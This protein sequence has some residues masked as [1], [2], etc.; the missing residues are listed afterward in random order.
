[1]PLQPATISGGGTIALSNSIHNSIIAGPNGV[2]L[3][4]FD[5]TIHGGGYIGKG[6]AI[7]LINQA[8]GTIRADQ[9]TALEIYLGAGPGAQNHGLFEAT[10]QGNLRLYRTTVDN[11]GGTIRATGADAH[12]DVADSRITGGLL[13]TSGG[14]VI[15]AQGNASVL[16]G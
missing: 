15:R 1:T 12:V 16:F 3:T 9:P 14:G 2:K 10:G 8:G 13:T 6:S 5:N 7:N 11:T 4:N